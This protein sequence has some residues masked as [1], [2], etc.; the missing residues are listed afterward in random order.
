M[1]RILSFLL[2]K[3]WGWK[4]DLTVPHRDKCVMCVAP[5][6][7][8]YDFIYAIIY[9]RSYGGRAHFLMKRFW[10]FWPLGIL[11]RRWGGVPVDRSHKSHLTDELATIM[12]AE[13]G[14]RLAVTPE[15]T[16][17][18]NPK[19]K[20]GFIYIALKANVPIRLYV[21]DYSRKTIICHKEVWPSGDVEKDMKEIKDYYSQFP[22]AGK[23]PA[24]FV[25]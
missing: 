15:G 16:R 11:L 6:T 13:P 17:S 7:S 21:L 22:N 1:K 5:H 2:Y 23:Y 8:N 24:K 9:D 10:F 4:E 12:K 14:F 25:V 20:H 3:C 19:W 18:A